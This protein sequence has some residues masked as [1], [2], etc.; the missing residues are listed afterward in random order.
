VLAAEQTRLSSLVAHMKK[1][2][3]GAK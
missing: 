1:L 2:K 3:L